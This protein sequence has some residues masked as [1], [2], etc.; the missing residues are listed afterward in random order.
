MRLVLRQQVVDVAVASGGAHLVQ[1]VHNHAPPL[2]LLSHELVGFDELRRDDALLVRIVLLIVTAACCEG[3]LDFLAKGRKSRRG[4]R[5]LVFLGNE[6]RDPLQPLQNSRPGL[7][8]TLQI[9]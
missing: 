3:D 9:D 1:V 7:D 8:Q 5:D 6:V 2:H 4:I